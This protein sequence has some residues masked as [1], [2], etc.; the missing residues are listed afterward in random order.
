MEERHEAHQRAL[1]LPLVPSLR[2]EAL[3]FLGEIEVVF[4]LRNHPNPI[5]TVPRGV[6]RCSSE[7]SSSFSASRGRHA[8][9]RARSI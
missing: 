1:R 7:A 3:H 6:D 8:S 9:I 2:A 5:S 4:G